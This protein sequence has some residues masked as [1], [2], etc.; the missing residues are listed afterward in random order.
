MSTYQPPHARTNFKEVLIPGKT[1]ESW[2]AGPAPN[3]IKEERREKK[4]GWRKKK[5]LRWTEE[6]VYTYNVDGDPIL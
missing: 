5:E 3:K 4:E 1:F 6:E 2:L